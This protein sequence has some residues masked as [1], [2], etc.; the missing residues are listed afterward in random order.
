MLV[1]E[2]HVVFQPSLL[3]YIQSSDQEG[4]GIWREQLRKKQYLGFIGTL[5][6]PV[7][8]CG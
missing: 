5:K 8:T 4:L 3:C 1:I 6:P 7:L 2:V